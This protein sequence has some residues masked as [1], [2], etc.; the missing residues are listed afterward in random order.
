MR[1]A[2]CLQWRVPEAPVPEDAGTG[3]AGLNYLCAGY[4]HFFHHID[5]YMQFMANELRQER[6]PANV[7]AW[8][9]NRQVS[10]DF[11]PNRVK[12]T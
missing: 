10:G 7:M 5:P 12:S 6:A 4:K 1:C 2:V 9:R 3:E 11:L 8:A